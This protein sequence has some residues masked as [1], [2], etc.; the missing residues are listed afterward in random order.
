MLHLPGHTPGLTCLCNESEGVLFSDD[1]VHRFGIRGGEQPAA[2]LGILEHTADPGQRLQVRARR[3]FGRHQHEEQEGR[4]TVH[5]DQDV[6][7]LQANFLSRSAGP[8][9]GDNHAEVSRQAE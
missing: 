9:I 2:E 7:D 4:L 1:V 3:G 6:A 8:D 5:R